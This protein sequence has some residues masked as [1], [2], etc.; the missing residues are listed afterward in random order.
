MKSMGRNSR[1]YV[2][3]EKQLIVIQHKLNYYVLIIQISLFKSFLEFK[4]NEYMLIINLSY[5]LDLLF[6]I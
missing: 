5:V 4:E 3:F 6:Q 2:L 1:K